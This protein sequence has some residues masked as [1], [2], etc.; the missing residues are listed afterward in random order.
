MRD[1]KLSPVLTGIIKNTRSH[2]VGVSPWVLGPL[3]ARSG[4]SLV[5]PVAR[6][7]PCPHARGTLGAAPGCLPASPLPCSITGGWLGCQFFGGSALV[8]V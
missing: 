2:R 5:V 8:V 4:V 7:L 6:R 3:V 1:P